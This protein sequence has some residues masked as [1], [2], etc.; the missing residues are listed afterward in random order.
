MDK[1]TGAA[2]EHLNALGVQLSAGL[3]RQAAQLCALHVAV[4]ALIAT[5]TDKP[6]FLKALSAI[7]EINHE[8]IEAE[9]PRLLAMYEEFAL[10]LHA[11]AIDP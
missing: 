9:A 8:R 1:Q 11:A 4:L 5:A 10:T 6:A 3:D 2:L 7:Y